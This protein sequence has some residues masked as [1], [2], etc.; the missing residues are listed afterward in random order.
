MR[1][2]DGRSQPPTALVALAR[3]A[4]AIAVV[5]GVMRLTAEASAILGSS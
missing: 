2:R 1:I 5:Q 4:L 3:S